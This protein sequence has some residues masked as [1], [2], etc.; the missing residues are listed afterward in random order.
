L[1]SAELGTC[2]T[3]LGELALAQ[4]PLTVALRHA[5]ACGAWPAFYL[6]LSR[7]AALRARE[8]QYPPA[9]KALACCLQ[10]SVCDDE[11]RREARARLGTLLKAVPTREFTAL[12][13]EGR[14]LKGEQA[15]ALLGV[16][17]PHPDLRRS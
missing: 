12:R 3:D 6:A 15:A 17:L 10:Q 5:E 1:A 9:I 14:A 8:G 2:F 7:L 13:D 4:E 11:T 16:A